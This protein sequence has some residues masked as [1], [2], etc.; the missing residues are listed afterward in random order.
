MSVKSNYAKMIDA[1]LPLSKERKPRNHDN[2]ASSPANTTSSTEPLKTKHVSDSKIVVPRIYKEKAP[3]K[4][5]DIFSVPFSNIFICAMKA[6]GKTTVL[7]NIIWKCIGKNTKVIIICNTVDKDPTYITTVERLRKKKYHVTTLTDIKDPENGVNAIEEFMEI[8]KKGQDDAE[9]GSE[10]S[11]SDYEDEGSDDDAPLISRRMRVHKAGQSGGAL[12]P[13]Q[14]TGNIQQPINVLP[15]RRREPL[16][17]LTAQRGSGIP[18]QQSSAPQP[19]SR[20]Q[21]TPE[22]KAALTKPDKEKK[23]KVVKIYPEYIIV[24]DDLGSELRDKH[25]TQL[26]KTNRHYKALVILST[27]YLNDLQPAAIRQL[28]Y[29]LLFAKFSEDKLLELYKAL[30]ISM[31]FEKFQQ[32]YLDAT[33][34]RYSFLFIGRAAGVDELRKGFTERYI[35]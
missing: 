35:I 21:A 20:P 15:P 12:P 3:V 34:D 28:G 30:Y 9:A 25:L 24:L 13:V 14:Y 29:V 4:A 32:I 19:P 7:S 27:Q 11:G 17:L 18:N 16:S 8:N 33:K 5:G 31:P 2:A 26:M 1:M 10:Q 23:R 6:S 22:Q